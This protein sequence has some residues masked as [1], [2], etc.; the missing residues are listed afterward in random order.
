MLEVVDTL[1][2]SLHQ[3]KLLTTLP[4]ISPH[5][6]EKQHFHQEINKGQRSPELCTKILL[7]K[8]LLLQNC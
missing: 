1:F 5:K 2:A 4:S 6:V 3:P 8:S 7:V